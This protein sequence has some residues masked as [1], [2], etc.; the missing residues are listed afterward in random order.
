MEAATEEKDAEV[1]RCART[2]QVL[3]MC[4]AGHTE[5]LRLP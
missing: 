4:S 2:E 5:S 3:G 1:Q